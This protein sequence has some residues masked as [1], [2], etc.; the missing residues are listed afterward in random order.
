MIR[1]VKRFKREFCSD[2]KPVYEFTQESLERI[3][4]KKE[5]SFAIVEDDDDPFVTTVV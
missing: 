1:N 3:R 2:R 5:V 4:K